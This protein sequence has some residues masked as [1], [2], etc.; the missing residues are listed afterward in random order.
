MARRRTKWTPE[1]ITEIK[2]MLAEGLSYKDI[3][4]SFGTTVNNIGY[5][6]HKYKI[7][8]KPKN[9]LKN[10]KKKSEDLAT[11][12]RVLL[13][14]EK[15]I[16]KPKA[17]FTDKQL[18]RWIKSAKGCSLFAKEVLGIKLQRHQLKMI[19]NM[20]KDRRCVFIMGRQSGK[21]FCLSI[22]TI[23]KC[24]TSPNERVLLIS[25]AQRQSDLLYRRILGFIG[26]SNELYDSVEKSNMEMCR[27]TNSSEIYSLPSTTFIRGFTEVT[28]AILNESCW[29][30][31]DEIF[32]AV[33]PMLA[34]RNGTLV[35]VSSAGSCQGRTWEYFNNPLFCRIQL[36]S[37]VN[38]YLSKEWLELQKQ[39]MPAFIY[40]ME[41]N[42]QFSEAID[43]FFRIEII[44]KC[45]EIYDLANFPEP[46]K[47]YFC[48][49]DWGRIHD[50]SVITIGY[51]NDDK[52]KV[53]NIIEMKNIPFSMQ[54]ERIKKLHEIYN[55]QRI[56]VEYAG[57][58]MPSCEHLKEMGLPIE[59]FEPTLA[60]KE[61]SYNYLLKT[62]EDGKITI[63]NH[64][65]LQYEVRIFKYEITNQGKVKLHHIDMVGATDDFV[66]SLMMFVF[67]TKR[68]K[69]ICMPIDI[70]KL[71]P[72]N[73][74]GL[75]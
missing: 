75:W 20:L 18:M 69:G 66:D 67:A 31:S 9:D 56:V 19:R 70:Q 25:P 21:D 17:S 62:M 24:T 11:R 58:S 42:A 72:E 43:N 59:F 23:W 52:I 26:Q 41:I 22:F 30:I 64:P 16:E 39:T 35:C 29:G 46:N 13:G 32:A 2:K 14:I 4:K 57:L 7:E 63:P 28:Y 33:E 71:D 1:K 10:I 37:T 51:K 45:T 6:I 34:V 68:P 44:N 74:L 12:I 54:V 60:N 65:K 55:F 61:E 53:T 15:R 36:P 49:V 5:T 47:E 8:T 27:F 38:K 73:L 3:A 40:D 50:S 48:G